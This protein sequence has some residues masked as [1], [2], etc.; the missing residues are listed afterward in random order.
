MYAPVPTI[1]EKWGTKNPKIIPK[2]LKALK[3]G[4]WDLPPRIIEVESEQFSTLTCI[5]LACCWGSM[6]G[7][8]WNML[9]KISK[10]LEDLY[11]TKAADRGKQSF[12]CAILWA[13]S[14]IT[15]KTEDAN[16][17]TL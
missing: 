15:S 11:E 5:H 7:E 2:P 6:I 14:S 13:T 8:V 10:M 3:A 17:P 4:A 9:S 16:L 12:L 1:H